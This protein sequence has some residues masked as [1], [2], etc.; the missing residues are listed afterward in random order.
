MTRA[1]TTPDRLESG[2]LLGHALG[3]AGR[4][5]EARGLLDELTTRA[6]RQYV[7]SFNHAM[8]HVG[9]GDADRA[10]ECFDRAFD[11][12][13]SWLVSLNIEPLLDSIRGD[14]RFV[15]LV[16]RVGLPTGN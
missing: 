6:T 5:D 13:S 4:L 10:F 1:G 7:P 3:R 16:Q 11:E 2:F 12:R 9:L 8:I 14:P 15:S